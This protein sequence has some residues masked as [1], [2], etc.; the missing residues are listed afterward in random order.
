MGTPVAGMRVLNQAARMYTKIS[1]LMAAS[2][3]V[4]MLVVKNGKSIDKSRADTAWLTNCPPSNTPRM[5]DAMVRPSIQ[6]LALTN[7]EEGS[8][9]VR[10]PYFAGEYAAAPKPTMA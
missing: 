2:G 4:S 5:M 3:G 9:S 1:T 8:S 6:P 7:W 10:M